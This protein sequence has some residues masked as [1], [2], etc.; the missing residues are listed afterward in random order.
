[1]RL[2]WINVGIGALTFFVAALL[3]EQILH[4]LVLKANPTVAAWFHANTAAYATYGVLAAGMF[5]E[6]G[7]FVAMRRFVRSTGNPG[8]AIAY[9]LGHGGLEALL[10]GGLA[11]LQAVAIAV[12][13]NNGTLSPTASPLLKVAY[14]NLL[15]LTLPMALVGGGERLIALA[16]QIVLSLVVWRAV[17]TKRT[18]LLFAAVAFHALGD[19]GAA[20]FQTGIIRS[21]FVAEG[22]AVVVMMLAAG[23]LRLLPQPVAS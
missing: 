21:V 3:L 22:G 19:L 14:A 2:S 6:V 5:E 17:E 12:M 7:R 10:I 23:F 8:T 16:F 11:Q 4:F 1:M 15:E 9:G 20:L 13:F 18:W